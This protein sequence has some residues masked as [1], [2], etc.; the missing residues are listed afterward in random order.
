MG[1]AWV[2]R[3]ITTSWEKCRRYIAKERSRISPTESG[4]K[5]RVCMER[6][7][8]V[9]GQRCGARSAFGRARPA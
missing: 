2:T 5:E 4:R 8:V 1:A 9:L 7:R 3:A 6:L